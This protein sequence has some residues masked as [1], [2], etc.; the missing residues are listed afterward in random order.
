MHARNR[1]LCGSTATQLP[2]GLLVQVFVLDTAMFPLRGGKAPLVNSGSAR[3]GD[4]LSTV[5]NRTGP[6][7]GNSLR[8]RVSERKGNPGIRE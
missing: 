4:A 7:N 6:S 5:G 1:D 8:L 3:L 2:P